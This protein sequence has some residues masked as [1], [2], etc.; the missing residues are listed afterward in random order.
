MPC[1]KASA[2]GFVAAAAGGGAFG[3]GGAVTAANVG[4]TPAS[5]PRRR[6]K[7]SRR[8]PENCILH[9]LPSPQQ[10]ACAGTDQSSRLSEAGGEASQGCVRGWV[11][12]LVD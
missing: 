3:E 1:A 2:V 8:A 11:G 10:R 4:L 12:E 5:D 7:P 6:N 9:Y